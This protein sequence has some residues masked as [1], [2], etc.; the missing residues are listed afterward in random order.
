MEKSYFSCTDDLWKGLGFIVDVDDA[1]NSSCVYQEALNGPCIAIRADWQPFHIL[2]K[3]GFTKLGHW[4]R[5]ETMPKKVRIDFCGESINTYEGRYKTPFRKAL[6]VWTRSMLPTTI[7]EEEWYKETSPKLFDDGMFYQQ[8]HACC[9]ARIA[10]CFGD[11]YKPKIQHWQHYRSKIAQGIG[12]EHRA[13]FFIE[14]R[15]ENFS[16]ALKAEGLSPIITTDTH[17]VWFNGPFMA[18]TNKHKKF[19]KTSIVRDKKGYVR[20]TT[21]G[22]A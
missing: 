9:G 14:K 6:E 12:P 21:N 8:I 3:E 1:G 22:Q 4:W 2:E 11:K 17:R 18:E 20:G 19:V 5:V 10:D 16:A 13:A 7:T 15:G